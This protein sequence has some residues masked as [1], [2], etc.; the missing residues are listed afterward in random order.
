MCAKCNNKFMLAKC[1]SV[2]SF[3]VDD[4]VVVVVSYL[5]VTKLL[6]SMGESSTHPMTKNDDF[7]WAISLSAPTL[8]MQC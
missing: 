4:A 6:G 3:V 5:T 2:P 1:I 8:V 7:S